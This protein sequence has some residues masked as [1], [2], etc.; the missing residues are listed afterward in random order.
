MMAIG[1]IKIVM[2]ITGMSVIVLVVI[3]RMRTMFSNPSKATMK[4]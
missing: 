4:V 2:I 1:H 3:L